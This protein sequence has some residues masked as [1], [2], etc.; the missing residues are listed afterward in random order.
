MLRRYSL[1][2]VLLV[3]LAAVLAVPG[4]ALLP[5]RSLLPLDFLHEALLPWANEVRFPSF[6]DQYEIDAVQ[7]YLPLYQFHAD[8]LRRGVFPSWNPF[9]RGGTAYL[10]N[11]VPVPFHPLKL[12]LLF[13]SPEQMFDVIAVVHFTLALLAMTLYLRSLGLGA[14]AVLFGALCWAFCGC[15]AYNFVHERSIGAIGLLPLCLMLFERLYANPA[16]RTACYLGLAVGAAFLISDPT[17]ILV[18]I[19]VLS[20]R[21]GG[22][23]LFESSRPQSRRLGWLC[24][25]GVLAFALASPNLLST[26]QG[27]AHNVRV[28]NYQGEYEVPSGAIATIGGL[29]A[30]GLSAIHPYA[31]GSRDS[32]DLLKLVGQTLTLT[33]FAGSFTLLFA[34]LAAPHVWADVGLR[35]LILLLGLG[36]LLLVP[37]MTHFLATRNVILVTF[38]VVVS[39]AV[40]MHRL[41]TDSPP[42]LTHSAKL[43]VLFT[44]AVW[45]C[46]LLRE[47]LLLLYGDRFVQFLR[48]GV[49]A[50]LPGYL[51]ERYAEWKI[52][53]AD[54]FVAL[55][56]LSSL[57][58]ILFLVGLTVLTIAWRHFAQT[59]DRVARAVVFAVALSAPFLFALE[60]VHVVD[61][62]RYPVPQQPSFLALRGPDGGP[63]RIVVPRDN[64]VDRLIMPGL[65]P[66]LFHAAQV[67]G[68]GSVFPFGPAMLTQNLPL[69]HPLYAVLGVNYL[70]TA[71]ESSIRVPAFPRSID[72]AELTLHAREPLSTRFHFAHRLEKTA[73]RQEASAR[74]RAD[75]RSVAERAFYMTEL[76]RAYVDQTGNLSGQLRILRDDATV[77]ELEADLGLGALL[78]IGGSYYPGWHASVNGD[79]SQIYCVD[80]SIQGVW[81]PPGH[82]SVALRYFHWPSRIGFALQFSALLALVCGL[83]FARKHPRELR[84]PRVE[85]ST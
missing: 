28:F 72:A 68:Y 71:R 50:R 77:I 47:G 81:L 20:A 56:R 14:P 37:P 79:A 18:Y 26:I 22:Y 67:Q 69:D 84:P 85:P 65:L 45:V 76:P 7:E 51:L 34:L 80:G 39:A 19:F 57:P 53:S 66:Q 44:I 30:L 70:L 62:Q 16:P 41:W 8:A 43:L 60:S 63:P 40:G 23:W 31:L 78:V 25:A 74:A 4:R 1:T 82:N 42:R 13:L 32:L 11:P 29:L 2:I 61:T 27:L 54:R 35:W 83:F 24:V 36:L 73:T 59:G 9:N 46:F 33:P 49:E 48:H 38:A 17:G 5:D 12:L 10:D 21:L 55:Q 64:P 52:Q 6:N 75:E 15:F 3:G 58:N